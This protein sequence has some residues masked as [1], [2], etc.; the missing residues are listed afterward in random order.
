MRKHA[1]TLALPLLLTACTLAPRYERPAAPVPD[2]WPSGEAYT[3]EQA[4][5]RTVAAM[6]ADSLYAGTMIATVGS[7]AGPFGG[8]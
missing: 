7:M 1:L 8:R 5:E 6:L 2:T 3:A 4:S